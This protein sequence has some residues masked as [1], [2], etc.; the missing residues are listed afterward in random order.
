MFEGYFEDPSMTLP[1]C[2]HSPNY[3][4]YCQECHVEGCLHYVPMC[5]GAVY[6]SQ[7]KEL[8]E[9]VELVNNDDNADEHAYHRIQCLEAD[10]FA[11]EAAQSAIEHGEDTMPENPFEKGLGRL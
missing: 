10:I 4:V 2:E 9:L 1:E 3:C 5:D 11:Y 7:K 8:A 6:E